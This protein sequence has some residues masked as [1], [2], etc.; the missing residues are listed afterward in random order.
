[1]H[2]MIVS[3]RSMSNTGRTRLE[4]KWTKALIENVGKAGPGDAGRRGS[5]FLVPPFESQLREKCRDW[6]SLLMAG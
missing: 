4:G 1:M 5:G 2:A 3:V 6:K